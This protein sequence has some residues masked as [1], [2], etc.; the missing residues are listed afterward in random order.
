MQLVSLVATCITCATTLEH[1][2]S[3][4]VYTEGDRARL[5]SLPVNTAGTGAN[6][7]KHPKPP[8]PT[9]ASL[10]TGIVELKLFTAAQTRTVTVKTQQAG[11][12][13]R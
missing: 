2:G 5:S 6:T 9:D 4:G 1:V 7:S 12:E 3:A 8:R 13:A 10:T 11:T